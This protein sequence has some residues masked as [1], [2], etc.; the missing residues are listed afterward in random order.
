MG[1]ASDDEFEGLSCRWVLD[2]EAV[3]SWWM[4]ARERDEVGDRGPKE[5]DLAVGRLGD[6][7]LEWIGEGVAVEGGVK[8]IPP[9]K[10]QLGPRGVTLERK[11]SKGNV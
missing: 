2:P 5:T 6:P 10:Y 9:G 11:E 8:V 7:S 4:R 1:S 3:A